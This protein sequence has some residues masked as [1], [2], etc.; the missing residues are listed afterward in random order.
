M[1]HK[2]ETERLCCTDPEEHA[3]SHCAKEPRSFVECCVCW[4]GAKAHCLLLPVGQFSVTSLRNEDFPFADTQINVIFKRSFHLHFQTFI[5]PGL[6]CGVWQNRNSLR[7]R[8]VAFYRQVNLISN[9][10][11]LKTYISADYNWPQLC[12]KTQSVP[13]SKHSPSLLYKPVS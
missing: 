1:E 8:T 5:A 3:D 11:L 4:M 9:I 12:L 13:R 6:L 2:A 7:V 10:Y